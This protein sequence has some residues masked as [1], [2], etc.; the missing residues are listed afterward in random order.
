LKISSTN[1]STIA[2][3][4]FSFELPFSDADMRYSISPDYLCQLIWYFPF[5]VLLHF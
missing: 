3:F 4:L 5:I 2:L 1:D